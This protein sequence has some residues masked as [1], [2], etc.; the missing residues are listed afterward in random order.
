MVDGYIMLSGAIIRAALDDYARYYRNLKRELKRKPQS[1]MDSVKRQNNIK[2]YVMNIEAIERFFRSDWFA[3]LSCGV[4]GK[5]LLEKLK[6]E[7]K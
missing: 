6:E 3:I 4:D 1:P 7:L 5:Y 2:N